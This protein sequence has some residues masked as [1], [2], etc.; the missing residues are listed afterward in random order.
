[1]NQEYSH[2]NMPLNTGIVRELICELYTGKEYVKRAVIIEGILQYHLDQGG[3]S[4]EIQLSATVSDV[5]RKMANEGRAK[6]RDG[7]P[8]FW[9]ILPSAKQGNEGNEGDIFEG[10][11]AIEGRIERLEKVL[12]LVLSSEIG[13]YVS[14]SAERYLRNFQSFTVNKLELLQKEYGSLEKVIE[15]F[16]NII[17][18]KS[19]PR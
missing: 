17:E 19:R 7:S 14:A 6:K 4:P 16:P 1:M 11:K 8:G 15:E 9:K 18:E 10:L 13:N 12:L 3:K 2:K 5:L